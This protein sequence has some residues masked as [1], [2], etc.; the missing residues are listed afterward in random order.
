M[1]GNKWY[2]GFFSRHAEIS[3][4]QHEPTSIVTAGGYNKE[5]VNE[6][7]E[8]LGNIVDSYKL[9]ATSILTWMRLLCLP[10]RNH[11]KFSPSLGNIRSEPLLAAREA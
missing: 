9:D 5:Q 4:R 10:S 3:L 2:Y 8:V 7:F 11:R 1:A 6:F